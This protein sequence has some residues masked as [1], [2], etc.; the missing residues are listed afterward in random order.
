[1]DGQGRKFFAKAKK[2]MRLLP[3]LPTALLWMS[4]VEVAVRTTPIDKS[5]KF[6]GV[7][8]DTANTFAPRPDVTLKLTSWQEGQLR[9][10]GAVARRWP[11]ADGPCLRQSLAAGRIIRNHHPVLR[12]G[13]ATESGLQAHAWVVV[14]GTIIGETR[15]FTPL[16]RNSDPSA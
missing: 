10:L 4:V 12:L 2:G 14:D 13:V 7:P 1:M 9:A 11:F 15:N 3:Y 16:V 8:L 6:L 5:S